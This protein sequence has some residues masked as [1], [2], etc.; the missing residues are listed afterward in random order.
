[1]VW[2]ELTIQINGITHNLSIRSRAMKI[3]K[4]RTVPLLSRFPFFFSSEHGTHLSDLSSSSILSLLFLISLNH[5]S[6]S[7]PIHHVLSSL[8]TR[9]HCH[10]CCEPHLAVPNPFPRGRSAAHA[11]TTHQA[12][13]K[14]VRTPRAEGGEATH[15]GAVPVCGEA[16]PRSSGELRRSPWSWT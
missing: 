4:I 8:L 6:A 11:G 16:A 10:G 7:P 3:Y 1:M 12:W 9:W 13:G 2:I 5:L 14:G 15:T